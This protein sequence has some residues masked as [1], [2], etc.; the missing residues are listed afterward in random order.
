MNI[1]IIILIGVISF[2]IGFIVGNRDISEQSIGTIIVD[3]QSIPE[4]EPY[5]FLETKV[6]PRELLSKKTVVL[7]V[8]TEK[9]VSPE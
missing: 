7:D 9:F 4:D 1:F 6:S 3:H 8:V 2:V 5:L